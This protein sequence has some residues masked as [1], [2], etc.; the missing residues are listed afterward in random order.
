M[1]DGRS[2][3][4][5]PEPVT[6]AEL[7]AVLAAC[8]VLVAIS[9]RSIAA[10][11]DTVDLPHF[12]A[13]VVVGSR[14]PMS[15]GELAGATGMNLSTASRMCDRLV[16]MGLVHRTEDPANRRQLSLSLTDAGVD[17]VARA[18]RQRREALRPML[19]HLPKRKRT[20]LVRLLSEFAE[21]GGQTFDRA[22]WSL[23][24]P[25]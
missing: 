15:L 3:A 9:A 18:M 10:V 7:D 17:V 8:R 22:L 19:E 11:D 5:G 2:S 13:L 6:A 12:R 14:G 23:G 21:A 4:A 25:T 16:A 24:W 1:S 20:Q